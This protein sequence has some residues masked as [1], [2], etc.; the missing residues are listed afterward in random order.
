MKSMV[1]AVILAKS[2]KSLRVLLDDEIWYGAKKN[3]NLHKGDT[4]EVETEDTE[5]G[6]WIMSYSPRTKEERDKPAEDKREEIRGTGQR[7]ANGYMPFVSN[8]VAHAISAGKIQ[9]E[10]EISKWAKAARD[11]AVALEV[12]DE[13]GSEG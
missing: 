3:C 12:L 13:P 5:F 4:I 2:G 7:S 6:P 9:H 11:A 1:E 10:S 8:T